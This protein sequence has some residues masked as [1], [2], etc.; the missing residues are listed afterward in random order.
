MEKIIKVLAVD[1]EEYMLKILSACMPKPEFDITTCS[2]AMQAMSVFKS[3]LFDIIILDVVMPS[4]DGFE[5]QSLIRNV[6]EDIPIIMLTA[7]V[8]DIDGTMLKRISSDKNTYYQSKSFNK[9]EL[10]AKI[11]NIISEIDAS[12][13]RKRYFE[14][15]EKDVALAGDVQHYIFPNWD[16]I[17]DNARFNFYYRPYMKITGDI[18]VFKKLKKNV[19]LTFIGDI[20]GH[21][22]KAAL[23][24][25]AVEHSLTRMTSISND[26]KPHEVL[27][28]LQNFMTGI[29]SDRYMTCIVAIID[30]NTFKVSFQNAGHPDFFMFSPNNGGII[31]PNPENKGS[32]PVGLIR[33]TKYSQSDNVTLDFPAD[34]IFFGYTDGLTDIENKVGK[35][36]NMNPLKEFVAAFIKDG[37]SASGIYKII[38]ALFKLGY[39]EI[40]DDISLAAISCYNPA[41]NTFDFIV[42]PMVSEVDKAAQE[43]SELVIKHTK[44]EALASKIEILLSEFMNNIVVHGLDNR[45]SVRPVI[46]VHVEFRTDDI[47]LS[48]FDKGKRWEMDTYKNED[49]DSD[50][51]NYT[52]ATS[53]R[54][55]SIIKKITSTIRRARYADKIN[56]TTFTVPLK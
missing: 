17:S 33:D 53:G 35:T 20:S 24:M 21:G 29:I 7:K 51:L 26:I 30:F 54:G 37:M 28:H 1:D 23:W 22:I 38:D 43:I 46:S 47:L 3:G 40:T 8:D 50:I 44:D 14:E 42:K 15:M 48:F 4:I 45:N 31:N 36:Y 19:F 9:E 5:L 12:N 32:V 18:V 25:S 55:L 10:V 6:R 34:T 39:N 11:R 56:E 27:N 16:M 13:E 41:P 2:N 49:T 52:R